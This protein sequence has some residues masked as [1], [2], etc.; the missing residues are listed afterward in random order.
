MNVSFDFDGTLH[1]DGRPLWPAMGLLRWHHDAG[2]RVFIVPKRELEVIDVPQN[3]VAITGLSFAVARLK[4]RFRSAAKN[5]C[6]SPEIT[7]GLAG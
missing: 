6:T 5:V 2:H 1:R 3:S 7:R 4:S